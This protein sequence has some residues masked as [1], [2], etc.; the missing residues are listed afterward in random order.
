MFNLAPCPARKRGLEKWELAL[1][2]PFLHR[3]LDLRVKAGFLWIPVGARDKALSLHP[4]KRGNKTGDLSG[5]KGEAH[6]P[7]PTTT[8]NSYRVCSLEQRGRLDLQ[9]QLFFFFNQKNNIR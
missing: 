7:E 3:A 8:Q 5:D 1:L 4:L 2:F 6:T 9:I